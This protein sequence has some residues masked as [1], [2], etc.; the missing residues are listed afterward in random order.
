MLR[1]RGSRAVVAMVVSAIALSACGTSSS[2]PPKNNG[3]SKL[4]NFLNNLK[5]GQTQTFGATWTYNIDGKVETVSLSQKPPKS[6]FKVDSTLIVNDGSN[7]YYC[8]STTICV[9]AGS[10]NPIAAVSDI[11]TGHIFITQMQSYTTKS[12]LSAAGYTLTFSDQTWGGI[13]STCVEVKKSGNS[14]SW[15]AGK[16]N[17]ILTWWASGANSFTITNY[18]TSPASSDFQIPAGAHIVTL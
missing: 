15:C 12:S 18:T 13:A 9:K 8:Q 7:T 11:F 10:T 16:S 17:G 5:Q 6:M 4:T 3:N 1:S 14:V 2:S